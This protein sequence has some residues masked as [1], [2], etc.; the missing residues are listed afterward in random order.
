[1]ISN[2]VSLSLT[3]IEH[4]LDESLG[5]K[6]F[7]A[8]CDSEHEHVF[9]CSRFITGMRESKTPSRPCNDHSFRKAIALMVLQSVVHPCK[10]SI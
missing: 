10:N 9:W 8:T 4:N 6:I 1:M 7:T 2:S 5:S 3:V